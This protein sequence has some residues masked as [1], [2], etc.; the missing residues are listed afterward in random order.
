[1]YR[2]FLYLLFMAFS[3]LQLQDCGDFKNKCEKVNSAISTINSGKFV[4][5][6]IQE[7]SLPHRLEPHGL[8]G[9]QG[10]K[11]IFLE[12]PTQ[13]APLLQWVFME[14]SPPPQMEPMDRKNVWE[15]KLSLWS[16]LFRIMRESDLNRKLTACSIRV[17]IYDISQNP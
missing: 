6:G 5:G 9:I 2:K 14:P 8:Q 16:H 13:L 12:S 11:L 10:L 7:T 4:A 1:M 15:S 3:F 17:F